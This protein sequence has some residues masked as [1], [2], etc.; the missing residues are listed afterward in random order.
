MKVTIRIGICAVL[1]AGAVIMAAF[2]LSD[3]RRSA[4]R[5]TDRL[6]LAGYEGNVAVFESGDRDSPVAV[7]DIPLD[8]LR[9]TD[10]ALIEHGYPVGSREALLA[11]LEDLG[12]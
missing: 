10:R 9:E 3:V 5:E 6:V 8:S 12:S 1:L 4:A 11:L 2:T 7:T